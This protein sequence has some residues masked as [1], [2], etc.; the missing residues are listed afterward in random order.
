M[1]KFKLLVWSAFAVAAVAVLVKLRLVFERHLPEMDMFSESAKFAYDGT[2][3]M[4]VCDP[5]KPYVLWGSS[6]GAAQIAFMLS[7]YGIDEIANSAI[8]SGGFWM[9]RLDIGCL[10]EDPLNDYL[11]YSGYYW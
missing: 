10:D 6:G 1:G 3:R 8:I 4:P 11:H 5:D 7:F 9:G 2:F